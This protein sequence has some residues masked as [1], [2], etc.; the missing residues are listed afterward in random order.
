M[1]V[2]VTGASGFI[3]SVLCA[4]LL[5]GG[6]D[7]AALV[8]HPGSEPGGTRARAGE[9]SEGPRLAE[10][11]ASER[12][13]CVVHLAA[14]IASQRSARK[15]RE[16]NVE[17]TARLLD[18]CRAAG[19]TDPGAGPRLVFCSTVVT[20]EAGGALLTEEAPL[21]V[22][23][24]YGRS[25]LEGERLVHESGLPAVVIRPSHVYGPGG[26]YANELL[27]L[28]RRPGR[29]AVIG[30][31]ENLWD[32]VHVDDVA[33]AIVLAGESAAAGTVYHVVDD[34]PITYYDF[35]ALSA[36]AI[37]VGAPRR[38]PAVL[39]RMLAG[40][41]AV[42]AVVRSARSSNARIKRELGWQPRFPTA[43]EGVA[44]AVARLGS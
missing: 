15:I 10:I 18:A 35:M 31:G 37:G 25:K 3:G 20:G 33:R 41:N 1:R 17:G 23:T 38:I 28:L 22:Q 7:V 24:P 9:L 2:F 40:S 44:D 32:V 4:Q 42:D 16:V 8:R 19:G 26:W 5:K 14:E 36:R 29:F 34:Q 11:L 39:A 21:P 12:P 6:H 13:D 30:G 43:R 27:P